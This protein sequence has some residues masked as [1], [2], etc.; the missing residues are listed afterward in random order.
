VS[1]RPHVVHCHDFLAQQSALDLLPES[2]TSSSGKYYQKIIRWGYRQGDAFI[3]ISKKTQSD[4]HTMLITKPK[5][6]EVVYNGLNQNFEPALD[7]IK[8]RTDLSNKFS[9]DLSQGFV[10]HVGGNSFYKNRLGVLE[11]YDQWCQDFK[12]NIPLIM[13]GF[14]P[15]A[16]LL[17]FKDQAAFSNSIHFVVGVGDLDLQQFYQAATVMLFPSLYEGF[18]WPIVEAMASGSLVITTSEDPMQEVA[19]EAGFYISKKPLYDEE[20]L[21]WKKNAAQVL[22][23]IMRLS[24]EQRNQAVLKSIKR[25][26]FFS[27]QGFLDS[28]EAIYKQLAL[29]NQ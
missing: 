4:L 12:A 22:D 21:A 7:L 13:V 9:I 11:I 6:S 24:D 10:L 19:G 1:H 3:S 29:K 28:I 8:V 15:T 26:Q 18:G 16:E 27:T 25:A 20:I 14:A 5:L 23:N 17:A 2:K